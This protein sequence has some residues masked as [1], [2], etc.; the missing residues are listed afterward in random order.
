MRRCDR[1]CAVAVEHTG[2]GD[3]SNAGLLAQEQMRSRAQPAMQHVRLP[4]D[5]P[6][7]QPAAALCPAAAAAPGHTSSQRL[8]HIGY[9]RHC[10]VGVSF[11]KPASNQCMRSTATQHPCS[12]TVGRAGASGCAGCLSFFR[13]HTS[14]CTPSLLILLA[15]LLPL[16]LRRV[17][18]AAAGSGVRSSRA[19]QQQGQAGRP[20]ARDAC[21]STAGG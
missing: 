14:M 5:M 4:A 1:A 17:A 16:C 18:A 21:A 9:A 13:S 8:A 10:T 20:G 6:H 11:T 12:A 3:G 2:G 15:A 19:R 7:C